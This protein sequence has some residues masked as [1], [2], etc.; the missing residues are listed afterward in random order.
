VIALFIIPKGFL[1]LDKLPSL[2]LGKFLLC[3]TKASKIGDGMFASDSDEE[4][5]ST[6]GLTSVNPRTFMRSEEDSDADS[7]VEEEEKLGRCSVL[8]RQ[9]ALAVVEILLSILLFSPELIIGVVRL[10]RGS[11]AQVTGTQNWQPQ[12]AVE[13]EVQQNLSFVYVFK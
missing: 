9:L 12:D 3:T 13:K 7:D 8:M 4:E 10:V 6:T 2:N 1:M 11:W 5:P